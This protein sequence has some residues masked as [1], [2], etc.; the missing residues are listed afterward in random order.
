MILRF[1]RREAGAVAA[2]GVQSRICAPILCDQVRQLYLDLV[3][4]L[5]PGAPLLQHQLSDTPSTTKPLT[6]A[7]PSLAS[8]RNLSYHA[9][10]NSM[11]GR[12]GDSL[13]YCITVTYQ[14]FGNI[15][16]EFSQPAVDFDA[17]GAL[18][19]LVIALD[20][21]SPAA[22]NQPSS[23]LSALYPRLRHSCFLGYN[24]GF[25]SG[26]LV[27]L[28][29]ASYVR[30]SILCFDNSCGV[31]FIVGAFLSIDLDLF[32]TMVLSHYQRSILC[33]RACGVVC[34]QQTASEHV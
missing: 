31:D 3:S 24:V 27:I 12:S 26:M 30:A 19:K 8:M 4:D 29:W 21:S 11:V 25:Q 28:N 13:S 18:N 9:A 17:H 23:T 20:T 5:V 1:P 16:R 7:A 34:E 2:V 10:N 32:G 22:W 15:R 6:D 14:L 33:M